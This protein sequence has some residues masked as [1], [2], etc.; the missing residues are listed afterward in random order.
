MVTR[1]AVCDK[2][3]N[4]IFPISSPS[5][6]CGG[7]CGSVVLHMWLIQG[8]FRPTPLNKSE[9]VSCWAE[10][11]SMDCSPLGSSVHGILQA[12]IL[13]W[14]A[15]SFYRGSSWPR[16]WTWVLCIASGFLT[17]WATV[18]ASIPLSLALNSIT[19]METVLISLYDRGKV[20][21]AWVVKNM[22]EK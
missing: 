4:K 11:D 10:S 2:K 13:E 3:K 15:I 17:I 16:D 21:K 20:Y 12:R 6:Q 18:E 14:V 1:K 9:S 22:S 5:N 19:S 7:S 8:S